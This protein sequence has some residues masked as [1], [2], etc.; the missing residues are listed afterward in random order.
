MQQIVVLPHLALPVFLL[1][2]SLEEK[3]HSYLKNN[4]QLPKA[5]TLT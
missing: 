3:V 5:Q 1:Q 4:M 2:D